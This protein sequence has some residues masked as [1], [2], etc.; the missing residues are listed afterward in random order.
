MF[1]RIVSAAVFLLLPSPPSHAEPG[2]VVSYDMLPQRVRSQN[3]DLAAARARIRE[4][5]ARSAKVGLPANPELETAVEHDPRFREWKA[6]IGLTQ[7]FP[8]TDR[9]RLERE[10]SLAEIKS[11]E[12][13]VREV[14]RQLIATA[15]ETAVEIL[16]LRQRRE[17]LVR[18]QTLAGE[19]AT[20][21]AQAAAKG[22][23]SPLDAGQARI[24]AASLATG[25][26]QLDAHEAVAMGRLKGL[27]GTPPGPPLHLSGNLPPPRLPAAAADPDRRAD[28]QA[29][30]LAVAVEEAEAKHQR[31]ELEAQALAKSIRLEAETA[32]AEME[33]WAQLITEI[34]QT[35]SAQ[36]KPRSAAAKGISKRCSAAAKN[37]SISPTP[38]STPCASSTSP[39]CATTQPSATPDSAPMNPL[40]L[41]VPT[42]LLLAHAAFAAVA[43]EPVILTEQGVKNLGLET[44]TVEE[45]DFELTAFALGRTEAIPESRS[46]LSSR[47]PGR[48]VENRLRLGAWVAKGD[49]L[50]LLESRQPGDPPPTVWLTAPADGTITAVRTTLGAPVEPAAS[51]AE[52]AD[53]RTIHLVAT[54]P[55]AVAGKLTAD[56]RARIRFPVH[57]DQTFT[58]TLLRTPRPDPARAL[59]QDISIRG[60]DDADAD[61]NTVGVIFTIANPDNQLRIGMNAECTIILESRENVLSVPREA[62][63]GGPAS[64]HVYVKHLTIPNAFD[65][66]S[67]QTGLS[68]DDRVEI[69]DGLFPGDEVATR[70]SYSLGF[71]G[72]GGG[73][74]LKEAL[75]AA[76]GH[77]HNEDGSE[78]TPEQK[79]AA[80]AAGGEGHDHADHGTSLRE[81]FFMAATGI[82]AV[83]LAVVTLRRQ[84]PAGDTAELS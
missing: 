68:N 8:V 1:I 66:V 43:A 18:Q 76:H 78:M 15:R 73:P 59:D 57:P 33:R 38:G 19:L 56:T 63:Q 37:A 36:R 52:I 54:L 75:D 27:L 7:R 5:T 77:E 23:G 65:R 51:L 2:V 34:E 71:A 31:T 67:V 61:L 42:A 82:L 9:L 21:L 17:L 48:V 41:I 53:L 30:R 24:E 29:K 55:Q 44:V 28:L 70:G 22:E 84:Q 3:P 74:S 49:P 80:A 72:S 64:R 62:I 60:D 81:M 79:A 47:I 10:V 25:L 13:E 83:L 26:G 35:M 40:L 6:E 11:A 46:T 45:A 12:A 58:G 16:A 4:A 14:E 20:A 39:A 32:R 69:L 50:V